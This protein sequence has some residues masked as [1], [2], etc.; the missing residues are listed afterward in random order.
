MSDKRIQ[1]REQFSMPTV[2]QDHA[3]GDWS[4]AIGR[5][6]YHVTAERVLCAMVAAG[7]VGNYSPG[8]IVADALDMT[9][10]FYDA[11]EEQRQ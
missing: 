11:L 2:R 5:R 3:T 4:T 6:N 7:G 9:D 10:V 8:R 1:L